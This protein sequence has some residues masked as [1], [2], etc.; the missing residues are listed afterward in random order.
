ML[1]LEKFVSVTLFDSKR[2]Q[3]RIFDKLILIINTDLK[4]ITTKHFHWE[5]DKDS[6]IACFSEKYS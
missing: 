6:K 2:N 1:R 4:E 5:P 3:S